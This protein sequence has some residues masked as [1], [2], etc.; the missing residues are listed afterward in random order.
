MSLYQ[1]FIQLLFPS[2][3]AGCD[4][5]LVKG[6]SGLCISCQTNLPRLQQHDFRENRLEKKFWG[7]ADIR[8]ATAFLNMSGKS[9][10]RRIIHDLKYNNNKNVGITLGKM[11]GSELAKSRDMSTFDFIIPVPL[12]QKKQFQRGYNQCDYIAAGMSEAMNIPVC[13]NH[14]IRI[15]YNI[16][17]TKNTKY[18]RWENVEG[19]F[20]V[21]NEQDLENKSIL[22]VD[23]II[24]TGS[25]IEACAVELNKVKGLS[26][27]I[28]AIAIPEK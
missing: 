5:V 7:R 12:H 11:F 19:I 9:L 16:S 27:S 13:K 26:L 10:V 15:R 28:A 17:Q 22:L 1:D 6:E 2:Y 14:L 8:S 25:T 20:T 23:D 18:K 3:C 4:R 24:T 21:I